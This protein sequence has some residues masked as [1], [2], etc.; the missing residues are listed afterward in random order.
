MNN[1]HDIDLRNINSPE[2]LGEILYNLVNEGH[3]GISGEPY[4]DEAMIHIYKDL[5]N[6]GVQITSPK[7][8]LRQYKET[9]VKDA[10]GDYGYRDE[11]TLREEIEHIDL[12]NG[13]ILVTD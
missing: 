3:Y 2:E 8:I 1:N 4:S 9:S 5:K 6:R 13:M 12:S 10:L 11:A 7:H